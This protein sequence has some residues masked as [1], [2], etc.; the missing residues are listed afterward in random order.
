MCG[1]VITHDNTVTPLYQE[2]SSDE[3]RRHLPCWGPGAQ[4]GTS[5]YPTITA[6]K[7]TESTW[8]FPQN[9]LAAMQGTHRIIDVLYQ[10]SRCHGSRGCTIVQH[11]VPYSLT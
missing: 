9:A 8:K 7:S 5:D 1:A 11:S 2:S 6:H 4:H 3:I 10:I